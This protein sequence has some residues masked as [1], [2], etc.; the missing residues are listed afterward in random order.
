EDIKKA[1]KKLALKYHP[2][3][4]PEEKKKEYEEHFKELNEAASI[5]ADDKKRQ[6]YDQYGSAAFSGG[7]AGAGGAGFE[8]Y[9]FSDVMSHFRSGSFGNFDDIF[10]QVFGGGGG[11][12]TRARRGSDLLYETEISL[13]EVYRGAKKNI[14]LNK[15][16]RCPDCNGRGAKKFES[17]H[18]CQGSGFMKRT[19]RTAFGIFQQSVP[20]PSCKGQGELPQ[21]SC[22]KCDG[23]GLIRKKKELEINIPAGVEEEMRLR[24]SGEGEIGDH[25]GPAGDLYVQIQIQEHDIF[26]RDEQDLHLTVPLTFAQAALGE[27]VEVPTLDGTAKLKIPAGT[28]SETIFR[29]QGKGLPSIRGGHHGDQMVKV[30][31]I[32]PKKLTKKQTELIKQLNEEKPAKGFF[33]RVFGN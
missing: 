8:G 18:H 4:A 7:G 23:E 24:V 17:C 19:Q 26:K 14:Q 9:D 20:C 31:I 22:S 10:D 2:D 1:F 12:R 6:Q 15:L 32:V 3:R 30:R 11:K 28:Q 25:N 27:D 5:L 33:G 13:D 29:M 16:E 21:D